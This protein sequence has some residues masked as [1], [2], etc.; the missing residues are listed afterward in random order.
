MGMCCEPGHMPSATGVNHAHTAQPPEA[1]P[2]HL[3]NR[4]VQGSLECGGPVGMLRAAGVAGP[5]QQAGHRRSILLEGRRQLARRHAALL[6]QLLPL[7]VRG[8]RLEQQARGEGA[9]GGQH[10]QCGMHDAARAI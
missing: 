8:G 3:R 5:A 6:Q 2:P 4:Q 10:A 9:V 1:H 7:A